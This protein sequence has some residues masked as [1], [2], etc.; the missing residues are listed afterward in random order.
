MYKKQKVVL[1]VVGAMNMGGAETFVMNIYRNIDHETYQF[2][3]LCYLDGTYDYEEEIKQLG[4]KVVRIADTRITNPALFVENIQKIIKNERINIVHSHVD[5]SSGYAML[6][7]KYAGV[8]IRIAHAHTTSTSQSKNILKKAWFMVLKSVMNHYAS[9]YVACGVDAGQFMFGKRPY[10]VLRNGVDAKR[11]TYSAAKRTKVRNKLN[12]GA[13]DKVFLHIGRFV[14]VK[15][16]TFLI[17]VFSAY[18]K[19][20]KSAKLILLGDGDLFDDI[21][22]K[23]EALGLGGS[24]FLLGKKANTEDYFSAAD[25]FIMPSVHEGLPV[26]L[27]EAQMNSL[28]CLVSDRIDRTVD[29]GGV[30]F[31][32]IQKTPK[33]WAKRLKSTDSSHIPVVELLIK[34]YSIKEVVKTVRKV[35]EQ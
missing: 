27:I 22:K 14:L 20:D 29:Y 5:F 7:A 11:F 6:A 16:H 31:Y 26:T 17:D 1:Q 3:F 10:V 12:I 25:V 35:Y 13:K 30:H 34:E 8:T 18:Y 24:V 33:E 32:S 2:V 9:N 4:G 23:V 21:K 28:T 19:L 15:N